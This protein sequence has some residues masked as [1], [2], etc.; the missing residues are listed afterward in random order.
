MITRINAELFDWL[1]LA[2]KK[3]TGDFTSQIHVCQDA[4]WAADGLRMHCIGDPKK[5]YPVLF[6]CLPRN[7][8]ELNK[9][10]KKPP[11]IGLKIPGSRS[12]VPDIRSWIDFYHPATFYVDKDLYRKLKEINRLFNNDASKRVTLRL[13]DGSMTVSCKLPVFGEIPARKIGSCFGRGKFKINSQYLVDACRFGG[14]VKIPDDPEKYPIKIRSAYH[15]YSCKPIE[16]PLT[17]LI[18][19]IL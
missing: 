12:V 14:L 4:V 8:T 3:D 9:W 11:G 19:G 18:A 2:T 17:A 5:A 1:K 15:G 16:Y 13:Y 10:I 6:S 7:A